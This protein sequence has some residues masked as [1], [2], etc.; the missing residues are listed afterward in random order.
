M[1][2]TV[3][4]ELPDVR[5]AMM[6]QDC[7][8]GSSMF[9]L[10][11]TKEA[12]RFQ[13]C[14]ISIRSEINHGEFLRS[15]ELVDI[16]PIF[17]NLFRSGIPFILWCEFMHLVRTE[18]VNF[19]SRPRVTSKLGATVQQIARIQ[20]SLNESHGVGSCDFE[21]DHAA[22]THAYRVCKCGVTDT[23]HLHTWLNYMKARMGDYGTHFSPS[24]VSEMISTLQDA[25]G[26]CLRGRV[27]NL[28]G[29]DDD[30]ESKM[31]RE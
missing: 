13:N 16:L 11:D 14:F 1:C 25:F 6:F 20:A 12:D 8:R 9:G 27:H 28:E 10:L 21:G 23:I 24:E 26:K 5:T 19:E 31:N 3:G 30:D 7:M 4:I 29:S 15:K 17:F 22:H 18:L 2:E